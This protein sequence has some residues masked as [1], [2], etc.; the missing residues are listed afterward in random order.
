MSQETE[1]QENSLKTESVEQRVGVLSV[2]PD[3][4][5]YRIVLLLGIEQ[6][7]A[8]S[9]SCR[10][11]RALVISSL[12]RNFFQKLCH[13]HQAELQNSALLSRT[14]RHYTVEAGDIFNPQP[15]LP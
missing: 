10:H 4:T 1:E 3:D 5:L 2:L 9:R 11:F 14:E 8:L 15:E 12:N 6:R 13:L 7:Q